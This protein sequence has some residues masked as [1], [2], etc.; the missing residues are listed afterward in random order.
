MADPRW[1][2]LLILFFFFFLEI[3]DFMMTSLL[4]LKII[5]VLAN[6]LILSFKYFL[7]YVYFKENWDFAN[8]LNNMTLLW[9]QITSKCQSSL[10]WIHPI[11]SSRY[12]SL[13][14]GLN[15]PAVNVVQ[16]RHS[17]PKKRV[18]ILI[19]WL[20]KYSHNNV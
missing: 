17:L 5:Y 6:F 9:R 15:R 20:S 1:L 3:N 7:L 13:S 11:T 2:I 14:N 8:D 12:Y 10:A 4:L 16:W 18:V 19:G